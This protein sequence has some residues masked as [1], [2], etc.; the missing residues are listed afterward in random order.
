M[1]SAI[2]NLNHVNSHFRE[3]TL[4]YANFYLVVVLCETI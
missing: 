3:H 2:I 1:S 4:L